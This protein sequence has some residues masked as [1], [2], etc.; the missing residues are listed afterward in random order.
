M[1]LVICFAIMLGSIPAVAA[2]PVA[3]TAV[4]GPPRAATKRLESGVK[5]AL[6]ESGIEL[7]DPTAADY[8]LEVSVT[9]AKKKFRAEALITS[10]RDGSA[11]WNA[12]RTY[13]NKRAAWKTGRTL[14][15]LSGAKLKELKS[16]VKP[17]VPVV[18]EAPA[19]AVVETVEAPP[20]PEPEST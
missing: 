11:I 16:E 6:K 14:G 20:P 10:T 2:P 12:Q 13:A 7:V 4:H 9:I 17:I 15:W 8:L 1:K 3:M 19:P 5:H 18:A